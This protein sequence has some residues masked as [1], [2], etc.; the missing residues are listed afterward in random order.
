MDASVRAEQAGRRAEDSDW[1]DHAVR[2]GL[3]CCGILHPIIAWLALRL[4]LGDGGG[5]ASSQGALRQ[6]ARTGVGQVSPY[7]AAMGFGTVGYVAKGGALAIV[8]AMF[9]YAAATHDPDTFAGLDR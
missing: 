9:L 7:V 2:I 3:V 6:V 1:M 5:S 4:G 8:G